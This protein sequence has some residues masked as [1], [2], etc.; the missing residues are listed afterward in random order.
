MN[1]TRFKNNRRKNSGN[2]LFAILTVSMGMLMAS[3]VSGLAQELFV[4]STETGLEL[5]QVEKLIK[6]NWLGMPSPSVAHTRTMKGIMGAPLN[7]QSGLQTTPN[8]RL[9]MANRINWKPTVEDNTSE[10]ELMA[11]LVQK[12]SQR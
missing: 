6:P 11:S 9:T 12:Q 4:L 7:V 1:T 5:Y 2:Y 8:G 10:D 3:P